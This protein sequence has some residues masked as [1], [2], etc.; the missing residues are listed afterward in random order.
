M[1]SSLILLTAAVTLAGCQAP[2]GRTDRT[3]TGALAGGA[4]GAA[5]GAIIGSQGH[6]AGAGAAIGGVLGAVT[7]GIIGH[8]MDEQERE[9]LSRQAPRTLEHIDRGQPLGLADIKALAKSGISDEVIISQIRAS[10]TVYRLTTAEIIELRDAGVSNRVID[11]M[12]NTP[13]A[14]TSAPLPATV[15]QP[16]A[17]TVTGPPPPPPPVTEEVVVRPRP[18]YVWI[19]GAWTWYG[20]RWVWVSGRWALPPHRHAVWVPG[21]CERRA[22]TTVWFSGHWR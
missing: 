10:R 11:F 6:R 20:A 22:G 3:A 1:K 13:H 9:R 5:T 17:V 12:I 21:R 15:E 2:S 16:T 18:G 14:T 8:A 4:L 7:G 19:P